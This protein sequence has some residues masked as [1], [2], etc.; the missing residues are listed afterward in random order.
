MD[1]A[2]L[3][4]RQILSRVGMIFFKLTA[5]LDLMTPK[6]RVGPDLLD[7]QL[8]FVACLAPDKRVKA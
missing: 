1:N 6:A 7:P 8:K 4:L 5:V 2:A 3:K